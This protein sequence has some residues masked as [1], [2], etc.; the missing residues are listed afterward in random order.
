VNPSVVAAV[1][2]TACDHQWSP[3]YASTVQREYERFVEMITRHPGVALVPPVDVDLV[4]HQHLAHP[5]YRETFDGQAPV[6]GTHSTPDRGERF[7]ATVALYRDRFG[8]PNTVW[9]APAQCQVDEPA[10]GVPP[11]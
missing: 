3:S 5:G 7:A 9:S 11:H 2:Q 10:P 1:E 8:E 6:H 4:W